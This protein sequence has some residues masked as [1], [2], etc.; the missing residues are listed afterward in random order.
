MLA[1]LLLL[2]LS[3]SKFT[4]VFA[5]LNMFC[6][7]DRELAAL[8][9]PIRLLLEQ[10]ELIAASADISFAKSTCMRSWHV[11]VFFD[12]KIESQFFFT[13]SAAR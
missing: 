8:M 1:H 7:F 9:F 6:F 4:F 13:L 2:E 11:T 5:L 3:S 10:S 12:C